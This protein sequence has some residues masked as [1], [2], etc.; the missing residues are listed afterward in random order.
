M[1]QTEEGLTVLAEAL[2]VVDQSGERFYEAELYRLRGELTLAQSRVQ[3]LGSSVQTSQ[4]SKG[5]SQKSK[6]E[7]NPQPLAP[8]P[9]GEVEREAEGCFQ[10]AIDIARKQQAKSWNSAPNESGA[11]MAQP[12]QKSRSSQVVV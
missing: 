1:G 7:T 6:V 12:R 2:T 4:K 8:N 10:K 11:L 9:Q 5:K 3:S